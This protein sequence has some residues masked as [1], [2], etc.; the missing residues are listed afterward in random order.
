VKLKGNGIM[1]TLSP[2]EIGL[3]GPVAQA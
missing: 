2:K 3:V 1:H